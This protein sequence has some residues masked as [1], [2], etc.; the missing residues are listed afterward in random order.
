MEGGVRYDIHDTILVT[1][2]TIHFFECYCYR[3]LIRIFFLSKKTIISAPR[4][5]RYSALPAKL[6]EEDRCEVSLIILRLWRSSGSG[7]STTARIQKWRLEFMASMWICACLITFLEHT[8]VNPSYVTVIIR[9]NFYKT[10]TCL[11]SMVGALLLLLWKHWNVLDMM[12]VLICFRKNCWHL[13][14]DWMWTSQ[15]F[16][17]RGPPLDLCRTTLDLRRPGTRSTQTPKIS[18]T[19]IILKPLIRWS[20]ALMI[21][22]IRRISKCTHCWNRSYWRRRYT[23]IQRRVERSNSI[24]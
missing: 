22:L 23:M 21:V 14:R 4:P 5:S 19:S 1:I 10:P 8:W 24:L 15:S 13:P 17:D 20:A 11:L 3:F 2:F 9:E 16:L 7:H 6:C 18:T 12:R